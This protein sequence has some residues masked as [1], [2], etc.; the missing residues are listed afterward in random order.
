MRALFAWGENSA[1]G[2]VLGVGDGE[3]RVTPYACGS[4]HG[5]LRLACGPAQTAVIG[6][7]GR[8]VWR[9]GKA[10]WCAL[11]WAMKGEA[12]SGCRV[13]CN[14]FGGGA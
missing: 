4:G 13:S 1:D 10:E 7:D 12:D 8:Y 9:G 5:A 2:R 6:R 11:G 3:R 14:G